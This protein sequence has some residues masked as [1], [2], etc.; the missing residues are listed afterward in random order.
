[1]GQTC[2]QTD[3]QTDISTDGQSSVHTY[4][5]DTDSKT[6]NRR[7]GV[8]GRNFLQKLAKKSC[9]EIGR[10]NAA[11]FLDFWR[12]RFSLQLQKCNAK[13]ILRKMASLSSDTS[14]AKYSTQFFSH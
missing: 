4:I 3:K 7:W 10:P 14:S 11:E 5:Q 2:R 13:V 8:M 9:D 1:M 6:D 12:K